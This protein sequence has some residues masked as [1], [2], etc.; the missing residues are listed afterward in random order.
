[1][2][3]IGERIKVKR[4]EKGWSQRDLAAKMKYSNHSTIGKIEAG[5]VDIPQSRVV[6]FAEVLNTSIAYLMGWEE[7]DK[8]NDAISDIIVKM[9]T[10]G[11]FLEV[12]ESLYALDSTKLIGVKQM[13]SA[14][15]K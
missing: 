11:D 15:L 1:M 3:N 7:M 2:N 4:I 13:L 14:F 6:Q 10:D 5:K 12:V 8:K 9:R